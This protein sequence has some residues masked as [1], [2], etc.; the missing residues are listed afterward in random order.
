M[1]KQSSSE[2]NESI[3]RIQIS[4]SWRS[5]VTPRSWLCHVSVCIHQLGIHLAV[6]HRNLDAQGRGS[7]PTGAKVCWSSSTTIY[8][9]Y[10]PY[11]YHLTLCEHTS[12]EKCEKRCF[13]RL[14]ACIFPRTR[15]S[16][17]YTLSERT[18]SINIYKRTDSRTTCEA[19]CTRPAPEL[20]AAPI[21]KRL[22]ITS[23][24][25]TGPACAGGGNE[26]R[27]G[28]RRIQS[29]TKQKRPNMKK[30]ESHK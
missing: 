29:E 6:A 11:V 7:S 16:R 19:D 20:C 3:A 21:P 28:E 27:E 22:P 5:W 13:D 26:A 2:N 10:I 24:T 4:V 9:P 1:H 25:P 30:E 12:L 23:E 17:K 18:H 15:P 14:H 8:I